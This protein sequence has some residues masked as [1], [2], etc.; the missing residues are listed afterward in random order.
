MRYMVLASTLAICAALAAGETAVIKADNDETDRGMVVVDIQ[1]DAAFIYVGGALSDGNYGTHWALVTNYDTAVT[2]IAWKGMFEQIP[3]ITSRNSILSA[4]LK[5]YQR[6]PQGDETVEVNRVTTPWLYEDAGGNETIVTG[7]RCAAGGEN[8]YWL[9]GETVGFSSL[10]YTT[11]D[12]AQFSYTE[13]NYNKDN[14]V[15]VTEIVKDMFDQG[16]Q[17]FVCRQ[18]GGTP[19]P[20]M[21][22]DERTDAGDDGYI[23]R[24]TLYIE[25]TPDVTPHHLTVNSGSGDG[26]YTVG[27]VV[28]IAADAAPS[29]QS[30][31]AWSGDVAGI[32]DIHSAATTITMPPSA[33]EVT[34]NYASSHTLTVNSGSGGG[35]YGAGAVVA[36]SANPASSGYNFQEWSGDTSAVSD[37]GSAI[38]NVTMPA[39]DVEVT[40]T[41]TEYAGYY[42]TV[43]S[44]IGDG[45]YDPGVVVTVTADAAPSGQEFNTWVGD[46]EGFDSVTEK[47]SSSATYIMPAGHAMLTATYHLV[48][49]PRN[50]WPAF[51]VFCGKMFGAE[52]EPLVYDKFGTTMQFVATGEWEYASKNSATVAFETSLPAKTYVQYGTTTSYGSQVTIETDRYYYLHLAYLTGLADATTY[53]YRF[54]A[55]D[56]RGNIITSSDKT[57]TTATP[58]SVIYVPS[59]VSGPPYNLNQAGRTY[60]VTED[61]VIDGKAFDV[62]AA[63]VTLDLGGHTVIYDNVHMGTISGDF[64]DYINLSS[65]GV[66]AMDADGLK[67]LN[68]TI[69]Q[70][71][72]ADSAEGN[73]IGFNP[74]YTNGTTGMEIA[75]VTIEYC[76]PQQV[77]IYN[78]WGGSNSDFHHNVFL[79]T[80]VEM[81]NRHGAGSKAI[82]I[83]GSSSYSGIETYNNLVKR[84]RQSGIQG[85]LVHDNEVY[86]DSWC[87]NSF[88]VGLSSGGEAYNNKMFGTG[89]HLVA[90]GWGSQLEYH[91]NFVHLEGIKPDYRDT[92]E[93]NQISLN[94]F[95]LT[96]YGGS[97]HDYVNN[98]YH[99]NV[100]IVSAVGTGQ[101]RGVQFFSD[102]YVSNLVFEDNVVKSLVRDGGA[103]QAACIVTQGLQD[104]TEQHLPIMYNNNTL[105]SDICNIRFGDYYGVGSNH[106]FN[107]CTFEKVG[108]NPSYTTFRWDSAYPS[109]YH[110]VRDGVFQGG[111]SLSSIYF[112]SGDHS[113][114]VEWTLT[115]ET[116]ADADVTIEDSASQIVYSGNA[117]SGGSISTPL[118]QYLAAGSGNT[119]HTPH[120]VTVE[121]GAAGNSDS[122]TVDATK[123]IQLYVGGYALTVTNG[124]GSGSYETATIVPISA[125]P[126]DS[127]KLFAA[128][129]G[130][131]AHVADPS[132]ASTTVTIPASD[133]SVTATYAWAY[134]LTVNSGT[135]DGLYL[136]N[137]L[138]GIQADV[139]P[140]GKQFAEWTGD[141]GGCADVYAASTTYTMPAADSEVTA[142]YEPILAGDLD[143]NGIVGQGDLDI[144]LDNWGESPPSDPRAD[145]S[146]DGSVGQ[147]DLDIVLDDWGEASTP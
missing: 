46:L 31:V 116:D 99:D 135:G 13:Y 63:N 34:A 48:G 65:I 103:T 43:V 114:T 73:S 20:Y 35:V 102:P 76:G 66:R 15:D 108:S 130:D 8:P 11:E 129:V 41:Y 81:I 70:G 3:Q 139:A 146:G 93:G 113:M 33:A 143:G 94:G 12:A 26:D 131:V 59:G 60:L 110:V 85:N 71:A 79:D 45:T 9:G 22:G 5:V 147:A 19:D 133:V 136:P 68:G 53:H 58:A 30:F 109:K 28:A 112:G 111:A 16:N 92:E 61:L 84:T 142:T 134:T 1:S 25:Y 141:V 50:W 126:P 54:V 78:H 55:E 122:V 2:L 4:T 123:T 49:S 51:S 83:Y 82:L 100:V 72:G 67:V 124:T 64:W 42:L 56:E 140:S 132:S 91:D 44:G 32:A 101:C 80:A 98:Y 39:S 95:R 127:G 117:G 104:R 115:V 125:N 89:Y 36:I 52:K 17:G 21:Q 23:C 107:G 120:T 105:I 24:P 119:Y 57:L 6:Y 38:T 138:V 87:I 18:V 62:S 96:Q 29:G 7:V 97:T 121:K 86:Q 88:G 90:F 106:R 77:G 37:L 145:P 69:K 40:A 74:I 10:D 75:G 47:S 144:I 27:T 137:G 14:Y 128:W 118:A